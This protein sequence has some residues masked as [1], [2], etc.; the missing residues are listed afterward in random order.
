MRTVVDRNVVMRP[1]HEYARYGPGGGKLSDLYRQDGS[2][3]RLS[4]VLKTSAR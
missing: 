2:N 4:G 3:I 1:V